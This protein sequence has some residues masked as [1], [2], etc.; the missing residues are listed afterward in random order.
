MKAVIRYATDGDFISVVGAP[1]TLRVRAFAGEVDGEV[2]AVGGLA[3]LPDGSVGAFLQAK[4]GAERRYSVTLH[5]AGLRTMQ[6][7]RRVGIQRVVALADKDVVPAERWL[8][9]L[10]FEAVQ[11]DG[12]RAFV[13][14]P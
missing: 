7:A 6:E 10:G 3:F 11:V 14:H 5:R 2:L 9:R 8:E 1:P 13:W 12:E 4:P